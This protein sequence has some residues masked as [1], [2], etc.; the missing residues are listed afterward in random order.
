MSTLL[1]TKLFV[2]IG[3]QTLNIILKNF[4][5]N[6]KQIKNRKKMNVSICEYILNIIK[7]E[8]NVIFCIIF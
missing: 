2:I 5:E 6:K 4:H 3:C 8:H 7:C 1:L